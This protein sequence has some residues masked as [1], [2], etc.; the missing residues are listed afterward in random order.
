MNKTMQ[1]NSV[2]NQMIRCGRQNVKISKEEKQQYASD[3]EHEIILALELVPQAQ[4][5]FQAVVAKKLK[6]DREKVIKFCNDLRNKNFSG[7]NDPVFL[8]WRFLKTASKKPSNLYPSVSYAIRSYL[9]GK[10]IRGI[11]NDLPDTIKSKKKP[12]SITHP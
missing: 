6:S 4:A 9:A 3:Y 12:S 10:K 1:I 5:T 2:V 8:L 7:P 11:R